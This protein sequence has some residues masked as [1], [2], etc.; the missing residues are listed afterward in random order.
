MV[1]DC[2]IFFNELEMLEFRLEELNEHVDYFV[3]VESNLTHTGIEKELFY[4]VGG[5]DDLLF[6]GW[7]GE[8]DFMKMKI[9]LFTSFDEA[10]EPKI[11]VYH[12]NHNREILNEKNLKFL[13]VFIKSYPHTK[14][15]IVNL[16]SNKFRN[17]IFI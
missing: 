14:K 15:E 5:F 4:N 8:D 10:N 12:M 9:E 2:F 7:G 16:L 6:E 13:S 1:I 17:R 3:L 11:F